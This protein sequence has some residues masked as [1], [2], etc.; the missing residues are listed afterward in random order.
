MTFKMEEIVES[1]VSNN[2]PESKMLG[3]VA[4]TAAASLG[5][6]EMFG[7]PGREARALVDPQRVAV[8]AVMAA[9]AAGD[10]P[11][12]LLPVLHSLGCDL[13]RSDGSPCHSTTT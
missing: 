12:F 2:R 3:V 11:H 1:H 8:A 7:V 9:V 13:G 4:T 5:V 10:R 6:E